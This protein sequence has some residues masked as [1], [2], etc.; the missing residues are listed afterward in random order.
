MARHFER[1]PM[2]ISQAV[3]KAERL[4]LGDGKLAKRL[5][6]VKESFPVYLPRVEA[7]SSKDSPDESPIRQEKEILCYNA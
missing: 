3:A 6:T 7:D 5:S 2:V 4:I 1:D